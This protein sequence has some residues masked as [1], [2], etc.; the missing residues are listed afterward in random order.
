VSELKVDYE[1]DKVLAVMEVKGLKADVAVRE[2]PAGLARHVRSAHHAP[3]RPE[4][5]RC[6]T[7]SRVPDL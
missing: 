5:E 2:L 3:R 6:G 4:P 7:A 1:Y